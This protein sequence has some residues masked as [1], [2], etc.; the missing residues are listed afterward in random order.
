MFI[1]SSSAESSK[2][3]TVEVGGRGRL[4]VSQ[5]KLF[6]LQAQG[7]IAS[8]R[9][10]HHHSHVHLS[11]PGAP[12]NQASCYHTD[13]K[14]KVVCMKD[15]GVKKIIKINRKQSLLAVLKSQAHLKLPPSPAAI[16]HAATTASLGWSHSHC[17]STF[18]RSSWPCHIPSGGFVVLLSILMW[19]CSGFKRLVQS[20]LLRWTQTLC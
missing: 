2:P 7:S 18:L 3:F 13:V 19:Q 14:R 15:S 12:G 10:P 6:S 11:W 4:R 8:L 1:L 16:A 5:G 17:D 9:T 20:M